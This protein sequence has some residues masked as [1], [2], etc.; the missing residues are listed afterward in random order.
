M[1]PHTYYNCQL[2]ALFWFLLI[3][4]QPHITHTHDFPT[5][6]RSTYGETMDLLISFDEVAIQSGE[7]GDKDKLNS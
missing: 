4:W 6:T 7:L 3:P 1:S 2:G 5:K